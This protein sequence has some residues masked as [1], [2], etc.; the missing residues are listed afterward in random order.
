MHQTW[1]VIQQFSSLLTR[2]TYVEVINTDT[3]TH[4]HTNKQANKNY[5]R[6]VCYKQ[7]ENGT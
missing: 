6:S 4:T 2:I 1:N 7:T 5:A 3:H